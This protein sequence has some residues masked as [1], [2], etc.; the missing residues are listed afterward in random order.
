MPEIKKQETKLRVVEALQDD[1]YKG[2]ARIDFEVM[3][4]LGIKRGDVI[5][6]KGGK[7]TV[8]IA[9]KAYPADVGE[10][11]I[12]IDGIIRKNARTGVSEPVVIKK[13]NVKEAK[14]VVVAPAQR[15]I[16]IQGDLKPSLLARTV[17][18]GDV[19][20]LGGVKRRRDIMSEDLEGLF[21]GGIGDLF[22]EAFGG[23]LGGGTQQIRF[24]IVLCY[25]YSDVF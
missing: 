16:M 14:K 18:K 13:A 25:D 23:Q 10:G 4:D 12:R 22:G 11:I 21:G 3:R 20:V 17:V 19:V 7:E 9:D 8:A 6:I 24:I 2:I 5:T 15:G 1:A